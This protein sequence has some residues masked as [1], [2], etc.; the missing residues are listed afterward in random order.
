M[1]SLLAARKTPD[2]LVGMPHVRPLPAACRAIRLRKDDEV[3]D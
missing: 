2:N 1:V 3:K